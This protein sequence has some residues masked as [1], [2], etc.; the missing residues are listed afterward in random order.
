MKPTDLTTVETRICL[1]IMTTLL[2]KQLSKGIELQLSGFAQ[3]E[4]LGISETGV[5]VRTEMIRDC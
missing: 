2:C 3:V 4:M 5:F 1:G